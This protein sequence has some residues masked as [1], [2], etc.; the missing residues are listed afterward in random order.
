MKTRILAL[1]LCLLLVASAC[2]MTA[3]GKKNKEVADDEEREVA[4]ASFMKGVESIRKGGVVFTGTIKGTSTDHHWNDETGEMELKTEDID[5][6]LSLKYNN[7]TFDA[8]AEGKAGGDS[9]KFEIYF[10]KAGLYRAIHDEVAASFPE[11][12][13]Y[14]SLDRDFSLSE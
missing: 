12:R 8:V 1:L 6:K 14:I 3:C 10:D 11:H 5:L 13:I 4:L 9:G 7:E 2:L